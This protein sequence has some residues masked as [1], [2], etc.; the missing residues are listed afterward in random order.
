[1]QLAASRRQLAAI[2][3]SIIGSIMAAS[4]ALYRRERG[5]RRW[6]HQ[7]GESNNE[8]QY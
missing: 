6:R 3:G 4:A 7:Y 2:S 1:M 8:N 5:W